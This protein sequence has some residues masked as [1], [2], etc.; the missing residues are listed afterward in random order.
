MRNPYT[1]RAVGGT[2][3]RRPRYWLR[4][5]GVMLLALAL[6]FATE[7]LFNPWIYF[8]GGHWHALPEWHGWGRFTANGGEYALYIRM[9][10][11]P[12]GP[13][14]LSKSLRG[15][16]LLCTPGREHLR[17]GVYGSMAKHLPLDVRG[18]PVYLGI[19]RQSV[20]APWSNASYRAAGSPGLELKGTWGD[21]AIDATGFL[22][23]ARDAS[24]GVAGREKIPVT[25]KFEQASAMVLWPE[26]P[27]PA[28]ASGAPSH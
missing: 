3:G 16:A 4:I 12:S 24:Q 13:P 27:G 7:A 28:P 9:L 11:R 10:P 2:T 21:S 17:L 18:Q 1:G 14:Y 15:D 6:M 25:V 23:L 26:C 8:T 22:R 20:W 5:F 19:A